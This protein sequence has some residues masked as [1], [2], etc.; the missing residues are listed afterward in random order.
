MGS[1]PIEG[2]L[3]GLWD[4][5]WGWDPFALWLVSVLIGDIGNIDVLAFGRNPAE[6]TLDVAVHIAG[7]RAG[8]V[9]ASLQGGIEAIGTDILL[10]VQ[11]LGVHIVTRWSHWRG[12]GQADDNADQ[13]LEEVQVN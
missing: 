7:L 3:D 11:H 4:W 9:V 5:W 12:G 8:D 6:F 13:Q 1:Q 2:A 10:A